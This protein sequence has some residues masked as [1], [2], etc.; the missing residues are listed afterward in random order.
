MVHIIGTGP[1]TI[2]LANLC[3]ALH[4]HVAVASP[5][6]E[7]IKPHLSPLI[8]ATHMKHAEPAPPLEG[9]CTHGSGALVS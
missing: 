4:Y 9:G 6:L 7:R 5:E 1:E 8:D 2:A 3:H